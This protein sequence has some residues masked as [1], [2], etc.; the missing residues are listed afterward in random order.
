M[1]NM[2]VDDLKRTQDQM[3]NMGDTELKQQAK[4]MEVFLTDSYATHTHTKH[5]GMV[6]GSRIFQSIIQP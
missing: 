1:K 2:S 5:P 6:P 3:K 4:M